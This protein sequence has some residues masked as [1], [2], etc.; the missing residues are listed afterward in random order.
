V[1]KAHSIGEVLD[2]VYLRLG[3]F[4]TAGLPKL[5]SSA[6][7]AQRF[8]FGANIELNLASLLPSTKGG[9]NGTMGFGV[10]FEGVPGGLLRSTYPVDADQL[11]DVWLIRARLHQVQEGAPM[12]P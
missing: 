6:I 7:S 11:V 3:V 8:N 9:G 4:G 5:I 2:D 10:L 12:S 1:P